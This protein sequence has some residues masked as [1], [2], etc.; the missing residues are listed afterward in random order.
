MKLFFLGAAKAGYPDLIDL[1]FP[2]FSI[3]EIGI[4]LAIPMAAWMRFRGHEWRP[5]LEMASTS[6]ILAILLVGAASLGFMQKASMLVWL[7]R[8][9]CP[10]MLIPMLYRL[11][12]YTVHHANHRRQTQATHPAIEHSGH[13]G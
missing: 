5:T 13:N 12:L 11:D 10:V 1:R 7:K 6:I 8:L 2:E 4:L 9:A 3:L